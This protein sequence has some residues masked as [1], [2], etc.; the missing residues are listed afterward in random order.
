MKDYAGSSLF[1]L[2]KAIK[3]QVRRVSPLFISVVADPDLGSD[4]FLSPGSGTGKKSRSGSGMNHLGH[5]YESLEPIVGV[6]NT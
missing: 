5:I 1:V 6:K 4:A 2:F 3:F